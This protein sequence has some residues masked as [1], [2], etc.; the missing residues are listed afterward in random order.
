MFKKKTC[1][2][3]SIA[4]TTFNIHEIDRPTTAI[5][6]APNW[7]KAVPSK[8]KDTSI[9]EP[10]TVKRCVPFLDAMS[11]GFMIPLWSDLVINV[12]K[13]LKAYDK[14][15]NFLGAFMYEG[16]PENIIN[17][18][19]HALNNSDPNIPDNQRLIHYT[20]RKD[21][22]AIRA[23]I[24][25]QHSITGHAW[26][27]V[28]G[29][30]STKKYKFGD[31]IFKLENPWVISTPKGWSVQFKNPSNSFENNLLFFDGVVDTDSYYSNVNF[32]FVWTGEEEGDFLIPKG[33]PLIQVI[34]FERKTLSLKVTDLDEG[35]FKKTNDLLNSK[36]VDKYKNLF[37]HRR[38][39][40]HE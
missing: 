29:I 13:P 5:K 17:K 18:P 37:S 30:C 36:F 32:P 39:H 23:S 21:D 22:L 38:R 15:G 27:Q 16:N 31:T 1:I 14:S 12:G 28:G 2:E 6:K 3:F 33:T 7:F 4:K 9:T 24:A 20:K 19:I 26:D 40:T 8:F 10:Q 11:Q 34:P 25:N 35:R